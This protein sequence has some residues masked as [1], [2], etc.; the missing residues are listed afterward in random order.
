MALASVH[1]SWGTHVPNDVV[2]W[3]GSV[4]GSA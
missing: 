3:L 2:G 4:G 1:R